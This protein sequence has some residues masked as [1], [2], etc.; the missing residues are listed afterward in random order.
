M[1]VNSVDCRHG[2]RYLI[3]R[4]SFHL[5]GHFLEKLVGRNTFWDDTIKS[6]EVATRKG[7]VIS[8][9]LNTGIVDA[10]VI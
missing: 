1:S 3:L 2:S 5:D 4:Q 8:K 9:C 10:G 6:V 7:P